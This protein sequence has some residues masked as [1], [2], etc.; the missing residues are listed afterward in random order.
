MIE[1]RIDV[2]INSGEPPCFTAERTQR[3]NGSFISKSQFEEERTRRIFSY[4][5][6][7]GWQAG[8]FT[9]KALR[10]ITSYF[11]SPF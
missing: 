4:A 10:K 5:K 1:K 11:T 8:F 7:G 3:K 6:N 2:R 9:S